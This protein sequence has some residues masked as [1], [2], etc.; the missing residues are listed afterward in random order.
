MRKTHVVKWVFG[1]ILLCLFMLGCQSEVQAASYPAK[2]SS[3]DTGLYTSDTSVVGINFYAEDQLKFYV[4]DVW[5]N[6]GTEWFYDH[7]NLNGNVKSI[8]ETKYNSDFIWLLDPAKNRNRFSLM[9]SNIERSLGSFEDYSIVVDHY[10]LN[11]FVTRVVETPFD[12]LETYNTTY[13]LL[14]R[15]KTKENNFSTL[16]YEARCASFLYK[17]YKILDIGEQGDIVTGSGNWSVNSNGKAYYDGDNYIIHSLPSVTPQF[18]GYISELD[19]WYSSPEGGKKYEVGDTI[20][21]GTKLYPHWNKTAIKYSVQCIDILG[22]D[23]SGLKI[24]ESTW[25]QEYDSTA[26]GSQLGCIPLESMYYNGM[27]YCGCSQKVVRLSDNVIYRYFDYA[28]YPVQIVDQIISGPNAGRNLLTVSRQGRYKSS[29]S[30]SIMGTDEAV[31]AYYQGYTYQQ[32]TSAIVDVNGATVYRYFVPVQYTITFDGNGATSGNMAVIDNCWY[33]QEYTLI[34]NNFKKEI[35]IQFD[36]QVEDAVCDSQGKKVS[37]QW[38]GWAED[39]SGGVRYSDKD[40]VKNLQSSSGETTLYAIWGPATVTVTA[41][42][43]RMGYIFAGWSEDPDATAGNMGFT[44]KED[45]TLYAIWK[46]DVVPYHVEYYKE[47]SDGNFQMTTQ[48]T[49]SN[50]VGSSISIESSIPNYQGFYLDQGSSTL[51]G[52]VKG[53]GSLVLMAYYRRNTYR[54]VFDTLIGDGTASEYNPLQGVFEQVVQVPND[55]PKRKG[56]QFIGWTA[57]LDSTQVYVMPGD[58]YR[59]PNHDQTLYAIW[60]PDAYEIKFENNVPETESDTVKGSMS[61]VKGYN[62]TDF[63]VPECA[64]TRKGYE[65]VA[66]NTAADGSGDSFCTQDQIHSL[67]QEDNRVITLYAIWK[68]LEGEIQYQINVPE[69][70]TSVGTGEM[71]ATQYRYD[72]SWCLEECHFKLPG[73]D[74]CGWNT[75]EDGKGDFYQ[76]QEEMCRKM[77]V[78]GIQK[79]YAVWKARTDTKFYLQ[80]EK[81]AFNTQ[82][83][84]QEILVLEGETDALVSDAIVAYYR[85]QGVTTSIQDFVTGFTVMNSE[86]LK[87]NTVKAD[88][89]TI[90][91]LK[92]ERK[93]YLVQILRDSSDPKSECYQSEEV[94]Y[95]DKYRFPEFIDGIGNIKSYIDQEGNRHFPGEEMQIDHDYFFMIEHIVSYHIGKEVQKTHISHNMPFMLEKPE[96]KE[97]YFSGWYW[98]KTYRDFAGNAGDILYLTE[99]RDLYAKWSDEKKTYQIQYDLGNTQDIIFLEEPVSQYH[100][101]DKVVLPVAAQL[102]IPTEYEFVGWYDKEDTE[103][104]IVTMLSETTYGDKKYCLQLRK[105]NRPENGSENS[106]NQNPDASG[107][108]IKDPGNRNPQGDT[109]ANIQNNPESAS[110]PK[111][112]KWITDAVSPI[113]SSKRK[114]AKSTFISFTKGK[115]TYCCN[116]SSKKTVKVTA[117]DCSIKGVKIPSYVSWKGVRYSVTQIDQKAFYKCKKL[118]K[119]TIGKKVTHIGKKAFYGCKKLKTVVFQGKKVKKIQKKAFAKTNSKLCFSIPKKAQKKY[120]RLLKKSKL[121]KIRIKE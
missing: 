63:V 78:S 17:F 114:A 106:G 98:D 61:G 105:K 57:D 86:V 79:L 115:I 108:P 85:N 104:S 87:K 116:H 70:A 92:L 109:N 27:I 49:L 77:P 69:H 3:E 93:K 45:T 10:Y 68:P 89:Q 23:P 1:M 119:V 94:L 51:Q 64:W 44:M 36:L 13:S 19:G 58:S 47:D 75:R 112:S 39:K 110:N 74:F 53:D 84:Y 118:R 52:T 54:V 101:G 50:Y 25:M 82:E 81:K 26:A 8:T 16:S 43:K 83:S 102:F 80:L 76:D 31:G 12:N 11:N 18:E 91:S 55:I 37:L 29:V 40:I 71:K 117:V 24:G 96:E 97:Y 34:A 88:E 60:Q 30:G 9:I 41:V 111:D 28:E 107:E 62:E 6:N 121:Q 2:Y 4:Q 7:T 90:V 46:P 15:S 72:D 22:N 99:D 32:S 67:Y 100:C 48:Y 42:P 103:K 113:H 14:Y 59:I 20:Q 38:D 66:W 120:T 56:Y 5:H 33:D 65:F 73:Y 95:E 35:N 21:K